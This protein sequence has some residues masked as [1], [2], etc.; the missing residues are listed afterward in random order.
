MKLDEWCVIGADGFVAA[1]R[2]TI[3]A[4]SRTRPR[5]GPRPLLELLPDIDPPGA[6]HA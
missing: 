4:E 6:A 1:Q 3:S 2:H 5:V